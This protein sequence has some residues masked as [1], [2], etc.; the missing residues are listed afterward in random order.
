[1]ASLLEE[2][3]LGQYLARASQRPAD[4]VLT[5]RES[6]RLLPFEAEMRGLAA[7]NFAGT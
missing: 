4:L 6:A 7:H 1:V 5:S 3:G 2:P